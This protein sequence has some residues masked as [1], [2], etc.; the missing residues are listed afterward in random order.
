MCMCACVCVH[1]LRM[2]VSV[3]FFEFTCFLQITGHLESAVLQFSEK[4]LAQRIQSFKDITVDIISKKPEGFVLFDKL[5]EEFLK[6]T[7]KQLVVM[8]YG[9]K[10]LSSV[11]ERIAGSVDVGEMEV[12]LNVE[13][14]P[15][16]SACVGGVKVSIV[17][18]QAID[19]GSIP[20]QRTFFFFFSSPRIQTVMSLNSSTCIPYVEVFIFA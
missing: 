11:V 9:F 5:A 20:G 10:K 19:P 12:S 6:Q 3:L 1:I 7:G 16:A 14:E 2:M 13:F 4:W 8:E 17:A 15:I 18:F